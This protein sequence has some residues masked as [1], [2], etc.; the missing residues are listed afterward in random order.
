MRRLAAA[1]FCLTLVAGCEPADAA[2]AP[3]RDDRR[4]LADAAQWPFSAL[5]RL[6]AAGRGFCTTVLVGPSTALTAAHCLFNPR[7]GRPRAL[8]D[9]HVVAGFQRDT[10]LGHARAK[11]V[12]MELTTFPRT[13]DTAFAP[14]DW[15]VI[16]L[17]APLGETVGWLG[18]RD[19]SADPEAPLFEA[20]YRHDRPY[21]VSVGT[22]C[23]VVERRDNTLLHDCVVSR[24]G[25]GSPLLQYADGRFWVVGLHSMQARLGNGRAVAIAADASVFATGRAAAALD[26]VGV[27]LHAPPEVRP[28]EGFREALAAC[29][30]AE[31]PLPTL[32]HRRLPPGCIR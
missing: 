30:N 5:G 24:G 6:N 15:A 12:H 20:G 9:L 3:A 10:W 11:R 8:S 4:L 27:A 16:E 22:G 1:L 26:A 19:V 23:Q 31:G 17:D 29:L 21:A 2:D 18:L 13:L 32:L 7:T 14:R 28:A 25:S